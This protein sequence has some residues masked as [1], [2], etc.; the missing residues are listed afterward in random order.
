MNNQK[1]SKQACSYFEEF[2]SQSLNVF[3]STSILKQ[4]HTP[5]CYKQT[6]SFFEL[7]I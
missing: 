1:L 5:Q 4:N 7:F 2:L 6:D 3:R